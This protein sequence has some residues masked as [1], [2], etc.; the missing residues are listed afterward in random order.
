MNSFEK[1]GE[2]KK[3]WS[4]DDMQ[5]LDECCW[6]TWQWK[7]LKFFAWRVLLISAS[8]E[9]SEIFNTMMEELSW[10]RNGYWE[11]LV[12]WMQALRAWRLNLA[13]YLTKTELL[14]QHE[15]MELQ[16]FIDHCFYS[17]PNWK[18]KCLQYAQ[19]MKWKPYGHLLSKTFCHNVN[20]ASNV[21]L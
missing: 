16:Y 2:H 11:E 4:I 1:V 8:N 18:W 3:K 20:K 7:S 17:I 5:P 6:R 15:K 9:V 13:F 10:T 12:Q 14:L 19:N 21:K